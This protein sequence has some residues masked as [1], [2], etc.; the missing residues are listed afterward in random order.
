MARE[1]GTA[2][3]GFRDVSGDT[4]RKVCKCQIHSPR[5]SWRSWWRLSR[6]VTRSLEQEHRWLGQRKEGGDDT[7]SVAAVQDPKGRKG[8]GLMTEVVVSNG[9]QR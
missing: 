3:V 8:T 9:R 4:F 6:G 7:D 2:G 1:F 5:T